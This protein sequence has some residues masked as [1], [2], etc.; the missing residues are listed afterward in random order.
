MRAVLIALLLAGCGSADNEP[1]APDP[2]PAPR[3][4][5][6]APICTDVVDGHKVTYYCDDKR[7]PL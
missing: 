3:P 5:Y 1:P 2:A 6:G 4:Q 7:R